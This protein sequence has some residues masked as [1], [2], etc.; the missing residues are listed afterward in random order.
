MFKET[1]IHKQLK[2]AC[3][4]EFI[5]NYVEMLWNK[6]KRASKILTDTKESMILIQEEVDDLIDQLK[7]PFFTK[8]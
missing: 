8:E 2:L 4:N 6:S 1:E 5:Y 7:L 3:V